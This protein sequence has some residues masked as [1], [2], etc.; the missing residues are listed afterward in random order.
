MRVENLGALVVALETFAGL[1]LE[2]WHDIGPHLTCFEADTFAALLDAIDEH[3]TTKTLL[4]A[5][6]S[7]D[8]RGDD[9]YGYMA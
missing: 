4:F 5:H 6:A 2:M 1:D 3:E 8:D 7:A 9:H